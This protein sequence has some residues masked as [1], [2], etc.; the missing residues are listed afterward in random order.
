MA[1]FQYSIANQILEH[2]SWEIEFY[3]LLSHLQCRKGETTAFWT[4]SFMDLL[5]GKAALVQY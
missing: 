4:M 1:L 5:G 3:P 2:L